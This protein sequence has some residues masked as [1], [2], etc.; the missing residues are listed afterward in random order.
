MRIVVRHPQRRSIC[1]HMP[2][3]PERNAA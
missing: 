1:R 3:V 2:D